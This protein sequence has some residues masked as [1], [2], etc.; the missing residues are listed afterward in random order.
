[1]GNCCYPRPEEYCSVT[2]NTSDNE[3]NPNEQ[4][5]ADLRF[6]KNEHKQARFTP[7]IRQPTGTSDRQ[8]SAQSIEVYNQ[9]NDPQASRIYSGHPTQNTTSYGAISTDN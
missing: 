7:Y 8:F 9:L 2:C 3:D 4:A 5:P 1:M 6:R